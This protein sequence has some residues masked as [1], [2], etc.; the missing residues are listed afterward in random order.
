VEVHPTGYSYREISTPYIVM[1]GEIKVL[2]YKQTETQNVYTLLF[3]LNAAACV[4]DIP[5]T[6]ANHALDSQIFHV[7]VLS[8]RNVTLNIYSDTSANEDNSFLNHIR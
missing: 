1:M 8:V 6:D 5:K 7:R 2:F 3:S 4:Q